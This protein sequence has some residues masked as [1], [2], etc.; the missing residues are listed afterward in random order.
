MATVFKRGGKKNREGY[1]YVQWYDHGGKRRTKCTRTTDAAAAERIAAKYESVAALRRDGVIDATLEAIA[2]QGRRP[3]SEHVA[4]FRTH[5]ESLDNTAK[6]VS[7]T[8]RQIE[9]VVA[10]CEAERIDGLTA[11]VVER[12]ISDLRTGG[13]GARTCNAY[14]GS[15][16]AFARW[17]RLMKRTSEDRLVTLGRFNEEADKRH[18]RRVLTPEELA[19]LLP[20]VEGHTTPN[21]SLPGPDRAMAYR[22]SGGTGFRALEMRSLLTPEAF[23]L[24]AD[25]PTVTVA[26]ACSKRRREDVQPIHGDL[27]NRLRPWLADRPAG[28]A[29]FKGLPGETARMLRKDLASARAAWISAAATDTEREGRERSDFLRYEDSARRVADFHAIGRHA[30]ISA[31][32]AGG[33]SVKSCQELARHS[34]PMLTIGRYAH[35]RLHDLRSALDALA[36]PPAAAPSTGAAALRATGTDDARPMISGDGQPKRAQHVA[37]QLVRETVLSLATVRETHTDEADAAEQPQVV[38]IATVNGGLRRNAKGYEIKAP[39]GLEPGV[40]DLQSAGLA[41]CLRR[42]KVVGEPCCL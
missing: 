27:A 12:A 13:A 10:A 14:V 23:D 38:G 2:L 34:S 18:V 29:V 17:L 40:A 25:S 8:I 9:I 7:N 1:W 4:D 15:L 39:P 20:F 22:L 41:T 26:A 36:D 6:Y 33:A 11:E 30:Y 5:L 32:V 35:T 3:L 37:Q 19:Y 28:V 42:Q 24:T 16:K 31:I 21:H